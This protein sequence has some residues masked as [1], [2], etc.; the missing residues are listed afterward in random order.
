M[1]PHQNIIF[2]NVHTEC[3]WT[4]SILEELLVG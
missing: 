1:L 2:D 4:V 3:Y